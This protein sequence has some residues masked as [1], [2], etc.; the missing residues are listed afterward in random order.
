M[1]LLMRD[2]WKLGGLGAVSR[3]GSVKIA[4]VYERFSMATEAARLA[5]KAVRVSQETVQKIVSD[6]TALIRLVRSFVAFPSGEEWGS[7]E[8][9]ISSATDSIGKAVDFSE[10]VTT[11]APQP[12]QAPTSGKAYHSKAPLAPHGDKVPAPASAKYTYGGKTPLAPEERVVAPSAADAAYWT[13][14]AE[15]IRRGRPLS[16]P[17]A[18]QKPAAGVTSKPKQSP[19]GGPLDTAARD[20]AIFD[21]ASGRQV[22]LS[23]GAGSAGVSPKAVA[24]VALAVA[25]VATIVLLAVVLRPRN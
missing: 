15:E 22:D 7:S 11:P 4:T 14:H 1:T 25:G 20:Q 12:G 3:V 21:L 9:I 24:G 18:K 13:K 17:A 19:G 8:Q 16:P 10:G 6:A 23:T 2:A 5:G